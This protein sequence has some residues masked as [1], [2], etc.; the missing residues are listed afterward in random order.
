MFYNNSPIQTLLAQHLPL[1]LPT[2]AWYRA[3]L[4][5]LPSATTLAASGLQPSFPR[6]PQ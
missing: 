3:V 6:C 2:E 5:A 4:K 1:P